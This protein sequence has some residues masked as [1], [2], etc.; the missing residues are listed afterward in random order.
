MVEM[1][2]ATDMFPTVVAEN[3]R[4]GGGENF[5]AVNGEGGDG[6]RGWRTCDNA[7]ENM[8]DEIST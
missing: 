2:E 8:S 3:L 5:V 6:F 1:E 4:A 7:C